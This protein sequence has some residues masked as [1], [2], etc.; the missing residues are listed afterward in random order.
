MAAVTQDRNAEG[1]DPLE[2]YVFRRKTSIEQLRPFYHRT[3]SRSSVNFLRTQPP[4]NQVGRS[5]LDQVLT[6]GRPAYYGYRP[7]SEDPPHRDPLPNKIFTATAITRRWAE[8][9]TL[10]FPLF[11]VCGT[12]SLTEVVKGTVSTQLLSL[13]TGLETG[14]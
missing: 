5:C 12:M 11:Q 4:S 13:S 1:I 7:M 9:K 8:G 3:N 6:P 10:V 2:N 14:P